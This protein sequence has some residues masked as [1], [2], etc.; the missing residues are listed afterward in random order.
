MCTDRTRA[1]EITQMV[2]KLK[3]K[4]VRVLTTSE[5]VAQFVS[6]LSKALQEAKVV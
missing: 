4:L 2:A 1:E 6:A 3:P 5:S